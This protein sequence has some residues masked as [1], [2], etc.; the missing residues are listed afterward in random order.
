LEE[1][2]PLQVEER[3][4]D[5]PAKKP[6]LRELILKDRESFNVKENLPDLKMKDAATQAQMFH[7]LKLSV[8]ATDNNIETGPSTTKTRAPIFM[9][10]V[11]ETE[12]LAQIGLEEEV[13]RDRLEKVI[14][15]LKS[16]QTTMAAQLPTLRSTD[17]D[18][19]FSLVALRVD[20]VRK[21]LLDTSSATRE[22]FVDYS[23]ILRELQV[24]RVKKDKINDVQTKIVGPLEL[25]VNPNNGDFALA[26]EGVQRLAQ[27]LDEDLAAKQ[28][29]KNLP[30]HFDSAAQA[31]TQ[32]VSL[33][34]ELES[35][36]SAI[37]SGLDLNAI[38]QRIIDIEQRHRAVT[39]PLRFYHDDVLRRIFDELTAPP[40]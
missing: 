30:R 36:Y 18:T 34:K 7:I 25:V 8:M 6:F 15:K 10:I 11:P 22:I 40:K 24:N 13:I 2:T 17:A 16:A 35:I 27:V 14:D 1:E 3:L 33:I 38:L 5:K 32:L 39:E 12:L 26:D 21:A 20:E 9:L 19:D 23:R 29:F 28:V 37:G 4:R 31:D